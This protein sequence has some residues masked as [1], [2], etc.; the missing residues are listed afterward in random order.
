[1]SAWA[2]F[3]NVGGISIVLFVNVGGISIVLFVNVGDIST[4]L[5]I[6]IAGISTVNFEASWSADACHTNK[7]CCL[8][9]TALLLLRAELVPWHV[10]IALVNRFSLWG[11]SNC[12]IVCNRLSRRLPTGSGNVLLTLA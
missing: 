3:V 11:C 10:Q 9:L 2:L 12:G 7:G 8:I 6:D 4:I 1:M 5:L